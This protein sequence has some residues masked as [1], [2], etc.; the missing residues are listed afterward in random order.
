MPTSYYQDHPENYEFIYPSRPTQIIDR[1]FDSVGG[2]PD[3]QF[4][5]QE[6]IQHQFIRTPLGV[7]RYPHKYASTAQKEAFHQGY[8]IARFI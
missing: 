4:T 3:L 1:E 5:D 8:I 7:L 6:D 2:I